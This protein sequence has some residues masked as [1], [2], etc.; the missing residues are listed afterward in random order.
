MRNLAIGLLLF[1][2]VIGTSGGSWAT[3]DF[4][5]TWQDPLTG[6]GQQ[7][8]YAQH[9]AAGRETAQAVSNKCASAAGLCLLPYF[10]PLGSACSCGTFGGVVVP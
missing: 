1:V 7:L 4:G 2:A 6:L 3:S 5:S 8:P 10:L 9:K